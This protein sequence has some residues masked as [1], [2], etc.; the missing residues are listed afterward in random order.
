MLQNARRLVALTTTLAVVGGMSVAAAPAFAGITITFVNHAVSGY[1][2]PKKLGEPV[3]LPKHSTFNGVAKLASSTPDPG[4]GRHPHRLLE[5][6]AV[7]SS[8]KLVG[9]V[10]T[11]VGSR[12][13]SRRL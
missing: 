1:L 13:R 2:T 4:L 7:Q 9:L 11:N 3:V 12:Y 10:P 5:R 6:P 8:L